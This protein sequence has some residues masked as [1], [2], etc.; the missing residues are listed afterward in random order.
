VIHKKQ[1]DRKID[2]H[3][4]TD[5]KIYKKNNHTNKKKKISHPLLN[6]IYARELM[7]LEK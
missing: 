7:I 2:R 4:Q 6:I 5:T 1:N 3:R